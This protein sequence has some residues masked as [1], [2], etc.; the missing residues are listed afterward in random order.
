MLHFNQ[1]VHEGEQFFREVA[2]ETNTP[3]DSIRAFRLTRAVLHTL[4]NRLP[5][6]T[7]LHLISQLP[8]LIKAVY[9]D[10]WKITD[11]YKFIRNVGDFIEAIREEG[12]VS[13]MSDFVSDTEVIQAVQAVFIV[14]KKHVSEGEIE[15]V[16]AT[17]PKVLRSVITGEDEFTQRGTA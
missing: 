12:G 6:A 11:D 5:T 1:Y 15:D 14:L 4:R 17:L 13:L 2:R 16:L 9:V 10:G 3:W 7:S 8:M